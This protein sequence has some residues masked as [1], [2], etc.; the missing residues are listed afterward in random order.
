MK[1]LL[2][3]LAAVV[4]LSACAPQGPVQPEDSK[5]K[6]A[7]SACIQATEG[8]PERLIPCKAVLNVLQQERAHQAFTDKET[9][10]VL[11]YQRCIDAAH[12]GNGQAYDAQ[13]GKLWQ[14]IRNNN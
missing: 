4:G 6:Q 12:T 5:L 3:V 11:D 2:F 10:R 7:Y 14:E 13:C 1:K 8:S 9:V